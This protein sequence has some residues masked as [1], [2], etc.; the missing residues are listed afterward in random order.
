MPG[1]AS[2]SGRFEQKQK[3]DWDANLKLV[4]PKFTADLLSYYQCASIGT[5]PDGKACAPPSSR[6]VK[7]KIELT[8]GGA[9]VMQKLA[10]TG[11]KIESGKGS[12]QLTGAI[13]TH[14]L[15]QLAQIAEVKSVSLSK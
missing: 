9:A 5:T 4:Q 2:G 11:F 3:K 10:L 7:V 6:V 8:A 12:L 1:T 13:L 14:R 15:K